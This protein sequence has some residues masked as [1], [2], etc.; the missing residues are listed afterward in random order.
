MLLRCCEGVLRHAKDITGLHIVLMRHNYRTIAFYQHVVHTLWERAFALLRDRAGCAGT[1]PML[2]GR[3]P[4]RAA[5]KSVSVPLLARI[6]PGTACGPGSGDR[7]P[8]LS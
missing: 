4:A 3:V 5:V 8:S 2:K 7:L 1:A 6:V